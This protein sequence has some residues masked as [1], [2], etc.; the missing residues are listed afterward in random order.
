M[1]HIRAIERGQTA[2]M[3]VPSLLFLAS[4]A[5]LATAFLLP[6]WSDLVMVAGPAALAAFWLLLRAPRPQRPGKAWVILD[7]SNVM[8][9]HANTPNLDTVRLVLSEAMARGLTPGVVFDANAGYLLTGQYLNDRA[10]ARALNLPADRVMVVPKGTPAD[11]AILTAAR[12]L[13]A[14]VITNDRYRDWAE[15]FPELKTPG[16]LIPG[17]VSQ[18]GLWLET[19]MAA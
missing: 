6:G 10:F 11:P 4:L 16:Y 7:G 3:L 9:W 13:G 8:H 18:G 5:G 17:G 2:R 19:G 15:D 14:R 12:D 1:R